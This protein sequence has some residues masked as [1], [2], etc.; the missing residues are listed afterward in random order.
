M[1]RA[2]ILVKPLILGA[3]NVGC[4]LGEAFKVHGSS[5][6]L[7]SVRDFESIDA[8][9]FESLENAT[10]IIWAARDVATISGPKDA[11]HDLFSDLMTYLNLRDQDVHFTY[12]SSGGAVYGNAIKLPTPEDHELNPL[13]AYGIGKKKNELCLREMSERRNNLE[14]LILRPGNLY[15][16]GKSDRSL[17]ASIERSLL[18]GI[19]MIIAGGKQTRDFTFLQDFAQIT[20]QLAQESS[21][22]TFN[23]GS[24]ISLSV[25]QVIEIFE[26]TYRIKLSASRV[27]L[28]FDE[29]LHS[30]LDVSRLKFFTDKSF[31]HLKDLL[32]TRAKEKVV[33]K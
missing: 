31:F 13:S 1:S 25:D 22:G 15:S 30:E 4:A 12:I 2:S 21:T 29:V 3:G 19:P 26:S 27:D 20:V 5:F 28:K 24:G 23:V 16:F 9:L 17:I 6:D 7:V 14:L 11:S 32:A 33:I 8:D 18:M 10:H